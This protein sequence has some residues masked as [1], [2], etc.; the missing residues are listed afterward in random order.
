M[1]EDHSVHTFVKHLGKGSMGWVDLVDVNGKPYALKTISKKA[2]SY[3][4]GFIKKEII[5][6]N[7]NHPNI[8]PT[9]EDWEDD[10]NAYLLMEYVDGCDLYELLQLHQGALSEGGAREVFIQII[11]AMTVIHA[12]GIAH[13]DLKLENIMV[14]M[15]SNAEFEV[16]II[17]FGLCEVYNAGQCEGYVGSAEYCAPEIATRSTYDGYLADVWSLGIVLFALLFGAFPYHKKDLHC[18]R[19]GWPAPEIP[20]DEDSRVSSL[21]RGLIQ[22]MLSLDPTKRPSIQE[23]AECEWLMMDN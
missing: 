13:R 11:Q 23:I 9:I 8:A 22:D 14:A 10:E 2:S 17:D 12:N 16:K 5:A 7:L 19:L 20:F 4:R 6:G 21:A 15:S 1:V 3:T 18:I